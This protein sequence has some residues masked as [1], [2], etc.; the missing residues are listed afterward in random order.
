VG[1]KNI[2]EVVFSQVPLVFLIGHVS[3]L[4]LAQE[5]GR[6][7]VPSI[8]SAIVAEGTG[9]VELALTQLAM[10]YHGLHVLEPLVAIA[11]LVPR[12]AC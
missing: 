12:R 4:M 11:T 1:L 5:V 6:K 8:K 2:S 3:G 9:H 7:V 10:T